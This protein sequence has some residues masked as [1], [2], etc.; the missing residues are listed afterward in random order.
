MMRGRL[1]ARSWRTLAIAGPLGVLASCSLFTDLKGLSR[2]DET[3][4][5]VGEVGADS[6][7]VDAAMSDAPTDGGAAD[8]SSVDSSV[9]DSGLDAGPC[10]RVRVTVVGCVQ[11]TP[12]FM[13]AAASSVPGVTVTN[14]TEVIVLTQYQALNGGQTVVNDRRSR[15]H[16]LVLASYSSTSWTINASTPMAVT[17]VVLSGWDTSTV[18]APAGATVVNTTP[19]TPQADNY[20]STAAD[21]LLAHVR[22]TVGTDAGVLAAC[23]DPASFEVSDACD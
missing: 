7:S 10:G 15:P 11:G 17:K 13:P 16:V 5:S 6:S 23:Y 2:G 14:G 20:P 9:V 4:A 18:V 1:V 3:D 12:K 8:S 19:D 22:T 21:E